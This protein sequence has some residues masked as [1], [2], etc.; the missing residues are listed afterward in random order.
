M[1]YE[2]QMREIRERHAKFQFAFKRD[3]RDLSKE[4]KKHGVSIELP[5]SAARVKL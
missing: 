4:L 1:F 5:R 3:F 2:S